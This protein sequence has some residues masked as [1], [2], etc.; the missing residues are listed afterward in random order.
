VYVLRFR[1]RVQ[2]LW[3]KVQGKGRLVKNI[4]FKVQG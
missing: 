2:S 4:W 1:V 3:L